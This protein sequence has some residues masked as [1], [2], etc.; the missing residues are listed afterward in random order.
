MTT[1][2]NAPQQAQEEGRDDALPISGMR[3]AS[4]VLYVSDLG[5]SIG[6]YREL[7]GLEV[8]MGTR[9]A[10]LLVSDAGSELYLRSLGKGDPCEH[11]GI[12]VQSLIWTAPDISA[13]H[14]CEQVLKDRDGY[15]GTESDDG[16]T[17]AEGR[18]PSDIPVVVTYLQLD[19]TAR[20]R[21]IARLSTQ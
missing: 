9:D 19:E 13:L 15:L 2:P 18:D 10:V 5:E 11:D 21:I 12:G 17:W 8:V 16:F 3:L 14:H 6:F 7:L 1:S 20:R 4:A